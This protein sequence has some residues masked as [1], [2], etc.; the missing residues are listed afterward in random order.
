[1][2]SLG[3][4]IKLLVA[5]LTN[6]ILFFLIFKKYIAKPFSNYLKEEK[7][8]DKEKE[9]LL[10]Q[11]KEKEEA[12]KA[13]EK[14]LKDKLKKE[15]EQ[16]LI[17]AKKEVKMMKSKLIEEAKK[18][19]QET[20]EKSRKQIEEERKKLEKEI[21]NKALE[22]SIIMTKQFLATYLDKDAQKKINE[23]IFKEIVKKVN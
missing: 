21:K 22:L 23:K 17:Q 12:L 10:Q 6:F 2:E 8:K 5:Q 18:E 13:E 20:L 1:M 11:T 9:I 15:Y 4:D 7:Q 14:K 19:A 16:A 3:V